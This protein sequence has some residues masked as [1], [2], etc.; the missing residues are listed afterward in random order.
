MYNID[1]E[2]FYK[3]IKYDQHEL[4]SK[5]FVREDDVDIENIYEFNEMEFNLCKFQL[6]NSETSTLVNI[7][8]LFEAGDNYYQDWCVRYSNNLTIENTI[9]ASDLPI[10]RKYIVLRYKNQLH[11][12]KRFIDICYNKI[13]LYPAAFK[14]VLTN[15]NRRLKEKNDDERRRLSQVKLKKSKSK[16]RIKK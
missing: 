5:L 3:N 6:F 4:L 12:L 15:M 13:I 16:H 10:T 9:I 7:F 8:E 11:I 1:F 2:K 14:E